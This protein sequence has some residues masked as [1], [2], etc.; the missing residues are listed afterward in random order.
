MRRRLKEYSI[1]VCLLK[2]SFF[3]LCGFSVQF[4]FLIL[5]KN[6]IEYIITIVA[7]PVSILVIL[8]AVYAV[9]QE[10]KSV[11]LLCLTICLAG[12]AYV[13]YKVYVIWN[14]KTRDLYHATNKTLSIFAAISIVLLITCCFMGFKCFF[15]FGKGLHQV[16][17][18]SNERG[19]FGLFKRRDNNQTQYSPTQSVLSTKNLL[20]DESYASFDDLP[21]KSTSNFSR[22]GYNDAGIID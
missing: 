17:G 15:N 2:F 9:R 1:F 10:I 13:V 11:M 16:F 19:R 18:Y 20:R 4:L 7:I 8:L 22:K 5:S 6:E 14:P 21:M 3:F 12:L